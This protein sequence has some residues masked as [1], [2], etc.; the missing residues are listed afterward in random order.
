MY[1]I[2]QIENN[3]II[4]QETKDYYIVKTCVVMTAEG[5]ALAPV[6]TGLLRNSIMWKY[7][8]QEGGHEEGDKIKNDENYGVVGTNVEYAPYVHFGTRRQKAQ[9]FL[10][11]AANITVRKMSGVKITNETINNIKKQIRWGH[12]WGGKK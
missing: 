2:K 11:L 12:K 6:D 9:P 7:K 4:G 1:D 5:K 3:D 10:S 8:D